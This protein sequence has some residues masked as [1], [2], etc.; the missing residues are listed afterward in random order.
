MKTQVHKVME[1]PK[2]EHSIIQSC[3]QLGT[4]SLLLVYLFEIMNLTQLA[5]VQVVGMLKM[6]EFFPCSLS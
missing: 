5:I 1:N 4:N 3:H 2:D 6:K